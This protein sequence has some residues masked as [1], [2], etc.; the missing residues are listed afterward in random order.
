MNLWANKHESMDNPSMAVWVKQ[1]QRIS[2]SSYV[3]DS[4]AKLSVTSYVK[5][6]EM[7]MAYVPTQLTQWL[8]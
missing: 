2:M 1:T 6:Q 4:V 7:S 3:T 5:A 8:Y